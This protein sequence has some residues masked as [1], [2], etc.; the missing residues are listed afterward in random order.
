MNLAGRRPAV[1]RWSVPIPPT[2]YFHA[3][4]ALLAIARALFRARLIDGSALS[5]ALGHSQRLSRS[6]MEAWRRRRKW[7]P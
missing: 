3:A 2:A 4:S 6:G 1:A 7:D 5:A